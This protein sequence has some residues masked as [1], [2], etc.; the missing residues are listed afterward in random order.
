[1]ESFIDGILSQSIKRSI[2]FCPKVRSILDQLVPTGT[3][4]KV[5]I[6]T[7]SQARELAKVPED[8]REKV[9]E[10]ADKPGTT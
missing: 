7:E 1:M 9:I 8:H 5:A 3:D 4:S 10:R 6:A 2:D